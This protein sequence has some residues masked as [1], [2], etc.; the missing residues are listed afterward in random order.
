[1]NVRVGLDIGGTKTAALVADGT[2]PLVEVTR[3][4]DVASPARLVAGIVA[5]VRQALGQLEPGRQ[6]LAVGAGVPGL[7]DPAGGTVRM[8]VN[9]NLVE[10]YPLRDALEQALGVPV[11]LENDVRVAAL[12][13][14]HWA[15]SR[16]DIGS[17]AYLSIGTGIAAGLVL[18]GKLYRGAQGMA[19]EIGHIPI[20]SAGPRCG[21]GQYGCLEAIAAGPAIAAFAATAMPERRP[22][23][24]EVFALAA[25]GQP[26]AGRV[27]ARAAGYLSRA[28]YL[29][30]MTYDVEQVALG[31]G[32]TRAGAAFEQPLR[33]AMADLRA[34]SP[35][36]AT[37]MPDDKVV[38]IPSD[39]NAGA[40]GAVFLAP[41]PLPADR[42]GGR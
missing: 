28:V 39:Y 6:L 33:R 40:R 21:C 12:G 15:R 16:S 37:M 27:V 2:G 18:D 11:A 17:L 42:Q 7:I 34:N 10:P 36:T 23:T 5:T 1:M 41:A 19:G 20:D 25:A 24:A 9:L 38:I 8:A 31:G 32:V 29:L 3:P 4:T 13:A 35:L 14:F 26:D 30:L 22:S